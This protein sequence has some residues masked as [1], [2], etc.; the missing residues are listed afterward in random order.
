M[1]YF[2]VCDYRESFDKNTILLPNGELY[3]DHPTAKNIR[4]IIECANSMG[5]E[6]SYFGGI[7]ELIHA[8]ECR[9]SFPGY[10]FLNFSDG[11]SQSYSRVQAPVLLDILDVPYS[12]SGVFAS[13]LMNNKYYCKKALVEL[14]VPM[15]KS[16]IINSAIP[17]EEAAIKEWSL[18]FFIKPNCEGSSIGISEKNICW[19]IQDIYTN[20][21]E[22][23]PSFHELILEEFVGGIDV[24]NYLI[25]NGNS[26]IINDVVSSVLHTKSDYS[27]YGAKEK[28]NKLRTLYYNEEYLP[29]N[30]VQQIRDLS[31]KIS[32]FVGVRDIC[33]LDYRYNPTT[34]KCYFIEINS[35]PRFSR[36]SEIGFIAEKHGIQFE[37]MVKLYIETFTERVQKSI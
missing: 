22:L 8:V 30:I 24:T 16:C 36:T 31:V 37:N 29:Y 25:G 35:A 14:G 32:K 20:I 4:E 27:I 18:P 11:M 7:P 3:S 10:L 34:Q 2:V 1:K 19:N 21:A 9:D 26:H 6:C 23:M 17:F 28:H 13:A 12:G 15:A 5:Y 33:R